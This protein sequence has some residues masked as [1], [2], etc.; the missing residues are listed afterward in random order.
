[1]NYKN[2]A[3][4][5]LPIRKDSFY[6]TIYRKEFAGERKEDISGGLELYRNSLPA[7]IENIDERKEYWVSF[8]SKNG[9]EIFKC[10]QDYNNKLTQKWLYY[11][12]LKK[13]EKLATD[14]KLKYEKEEEFRKRL[15]I[16]LEEHKEGKQAIWLE[17]YYLS[18]AKRYGFLIDFKFVKNP[19]IPF[20]PPYA[21]KIQQLSFSLDRNFRSNRNFYID[22]YNKVKY[23]IDSYFSNLFPLGDGIVEVSKEFF[24]IQSESLDTKKYIFADQKEDNSQFIGLKQNGPLEGITDST[25]FYFIFHEQ[26]KRFAVELAGALSG[27]T[28]QNIFPGMET[29][30]RIPFVPGS[31]GNVKSIP[32]QDYSKTTSEDVM[33]KLKEENYLNKIPILII[34]SKRDEESMKTYYRTKH[35]FISNNI[36]LQVVT[37]DLLRNTESF[38]WSVSNIALQIFAKL[39]G[40][41][42]KVK[43]SNE[44]C[45]IIG[46]GQAH[47]RKIENGDEKI[48]KFLSYSIL[49]DSS[50]LY[51]D[52][53]VMAESESEDTYLAQLKD[54]LKKIISD[55]KNEFDKF[56]IHTPFKI[57]REEIAAVEEVI[58]EIKTDITYEKIEFL[59]LKINDKNKYF[60]YNTEANSLVP[61]ES[62]YVKLSTNEY[63][64]WF[65]G[66]QYHNPNVYKRY[67]GPTHIEFYY[68]SSDLEE[69]EKIK[70]LQDTINLSGANWRG[71]NAKSLPVSIY[72]CQ[73]VARFIKEFYEYGYQEFKID[74]L[75]PWFL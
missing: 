38:K 7:T 72:Y 33:K 30:F 8:E 19:N 74:N 62:T 67:S 25:L 46:I 45:L 20:A 39:G 17:P 10:K 50:G 13:I 3:L 31:N 14:G 65:E 35:D 2:I 1:M 5:F 40:K 55:H 27:S 32:I 37:L 44:K 16:V 73:L 9:F 48:E 52:L 69:S 6:F 26:E 28:Y 60:G 29:I 70:Y 42:W 22:R 63:L 66:L 75:K 71:F 54:N 47:R 18:I 36:P 68:A 61:Y 64:L 51:K 59:V 15:Y 21:R 23:S 57:K 12:L 41:P 58:R 49:T 43:P 53:K 34:P 4:N 24:S 56:V 11:L